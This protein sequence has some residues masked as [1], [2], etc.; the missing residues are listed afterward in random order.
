V[1]LTDLHPTGVLAPE[2]SPESAR[3]I[4][5]WKA[6]AKV[7]DPEISQPITKLGMVAAVEF[8]GENIEVVI[9]LTI[10]GCP[11]RETIS[12]D[13]TR[14]LE[15]LVS[16]N[17]TVNLQSMTKEQRLALQDD[18]TGARPKN[19][20]GKDSLTKIY[21]VAS[22]KGGVGK[23]T[24]TA[25]LAA[26]LARTGLSVGLIDADVYGFSIPRIMGI[27]TKPTKV[28]DMILPPVAH[29]VKVMSIGLLVA[30]DQPVVWRGPMLHKA[31]QQF[32]TDTYWGDLDVLLVDLPPGT[33]DIAISSAELLPD[34]QLLVITTPESTSSDVA[35]RAGQISIQTHQPVAGVI[36]NM[37]PMELQDGTVVNI[38][39]SGG[40]IAVSEHLTSVLEKD[41]PLMATIPLDPTLRS[42]SEKGI[43][44][45]IASP[46]CSAASA[47]SK[48][49][50]ELASAP[51][52]L[53][54]RKLPVSP[55]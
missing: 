27:S 35:A 6:L 15:D 9:R 14:A 23:S 40:G 18:L 11:M 43:P 17:V 12:A 33:G 48:L 38:F 22:G 3:E 24:I 47:L 39:G 50:H 7:I 46:N 16:G 21:A 41:I 49:V 8:S 45:V 34:A 25:N 30:K 20:F 13:V 36:E 32:I 54:G 53:F 19:P 26:G 55:R 2:V 28:Q 52:S 31:L 10:S 4:Q 42:D 51:R 1:R 5:A 29:G 44:S 37:G